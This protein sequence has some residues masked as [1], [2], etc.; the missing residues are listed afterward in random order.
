[1]HTC[2]NRYGLTKAK[3]HALRS[4]AGAKV[5]L[6]EPRHV[7]HLTRRALN[8]FT[9]FVA[10]ADCIRIR[11]AGNRQASVERIDV[12]GQL[13]NKYSQRMEVDKVPEKDRVCR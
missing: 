1:V 2:P 6:S 9:D 5:Q 11:N 13:F 8:E 12:R 7:C 4:Y 3:K 10:S